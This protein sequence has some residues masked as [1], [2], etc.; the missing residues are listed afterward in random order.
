LNKNKGSTL[1]LYIQIP[2]FNEAEHLPLTLSQ[3]PKH[4]RGID[5]IRFLVIDDG[6]TDNT[7][8]VARK[9]G[10]HYVVRMKKNKGLAR[11][12]MA[13]LDACL[14]LGADIIV[15]TDA[16][17]QYRGE[18]IKALI[19]PI[20]DGKADVVIGDRKTKDVHHFS[21]SKKRLQALGSWAVR[22][23][24]GTDIPDATSGFRAFTRDAALQMNVVS[25]FTYTLET[26][27]QAGK[28][29]LAI[30][31]VPVRTNEQVRE[32]RLFTGNW[33][34]IKKSVA[35]IAR[36][37]TM[38]EPLKMFSYIGSAIFAIGFLIG[39]RFL[40]FYFFDHG[41]GHI[42]SL[43]LTAILMLVGFQIFV[44]GLM[45]DIIGSNRQLIENVLYSVRKIQLGTGEDGNRQQVKRR[46][47]SRDR[48]RT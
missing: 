36:I 38:Y 32:S 47:S 4:I 21:N 7:A 1:K 17:N 31:H 46:T 20:L 37:Y 23:V 28:K 39:L 11:V 9:L 10:V 33:S 34:Y 24:S 29:S 18:D 42:Q 48:R 40:I 6:S 43:I 19:Q 25:Q 45:A 5:E 13:G 30:T 14:R 44:L 35:T 12:F 15:N 27:I 41:A 22:Q 2:C 26:I 3:L 16:D 8:E